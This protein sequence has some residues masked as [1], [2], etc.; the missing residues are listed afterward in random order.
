ML[1]Y[2]EVYTYIASENIPTMPL[3]L[4]VGIKRTIKKSAG[5]TVVDNPEDGY[6][7]GPLRD[8]IWTEKE[9]SIDRQLRDPE[10]IILQGS[11]NCSISIDKITKLSLGPLKLRYVV[12]EVDLYFQLFDIGSSTIKD[13]YFKRKLL[14]NIRSSCWIGEL[15][16]KVKLRSKELV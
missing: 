6:N 11:K 14:P 1:K 9:L 3:E 5:V 12:D 7:I 4:R 2:T 15:N 16:H 13:D 10:L 8:I